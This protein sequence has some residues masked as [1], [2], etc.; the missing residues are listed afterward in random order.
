[1]VDRSVAGL[2][3]CLVTAVL[4][5]SCRPTGTPTPGSP[6]TGPT[7]RYVRPAGEG[8][9]DGSSWANAMKGLPASLERNTVYWLSAGLYGG[10]TFNDPARGRAEIT[11]RKATLE[12]HGDDT[13]WN[14]SYG[15]GQAVFGP[16]RFEGSH[17][18][19]D[20]SD[21]NGI[22]A[23]G[24]MGVEATVEIEGS[25]ITL[26]HVEVDG[27]FTRADGKQTAGSCNG[28]NVNGDYALLDS[29]EI[30]AI[31][32]DG[33]GIYS[34]HA[35]L[36]HSTIHDLDGCGT[37]GGCGRCF[38]GHSD[39]I[40]LS[41]SSYVELSGNLVYDVR[42]NAALFMDDWSG[43]PIR[44]LVVYN[45]VFYTPDTGF[46]VYLQKVDSAKVH[47][48]VI[49][50]KSQ[51]SRYGG[52]SI[53]LHV[54]KLQMHNNIILNINY[55]HMG[56]NYDPDEH[57]LDYNLFGM[58]DPDEYAAH[59][60]DLVGNPRFARVPLSGDD[61]D[62]DLG[63]LELD[64]FRPSAPEVRDTGTAP[65]GMPAFDITGEPRPTGSA[66]DLGPF[67]L[68]PR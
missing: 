53:G 55:S 68:S 8:T 23:L 3:V 29:C 28:V 37:D 63:A 57:G 16:L 35:R 21:T 40:E 19:I 12:A 2:L 39:G 15:R 30:H 46:A 38:N 34:D 62:H 42:S 26:R 27:G 11:L 44:D 17:Y 54:T 49:W 9:R 32:D 48:N 66:W 59:G 41:G 61:E 22:K 64:D 36:L 7:V 47:N 58:V 24:R 56:A 18:V 25:H 67:E 20:G 45:N 52:L 4:A 65:S 60:H 10:H 6:K 5:G 43:S 13:G 51:G 50:G 14:A 33:L 1:M 31:A